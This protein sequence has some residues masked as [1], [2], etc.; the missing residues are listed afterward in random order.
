VVDDGEAPD[1]LVP[2]DL[3]TDTQSPEIE[4]VPF[5]RVD[6]QCLLHVLLLVV[7]G[8]ACQISELWRTTDRSVRETKRL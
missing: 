7:A 1:C 5:S 8:T 4:A 6:Y 2:I 3:A